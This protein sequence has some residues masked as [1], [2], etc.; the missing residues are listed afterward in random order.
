MNVMSQPV[1][2]HDLVLSLDDRIQYLAYKDL[3]DAVQKNNADSGSVVVVNAKTGEILA[4]ANVPSYNPNHRPGSA[5]SSYRNRA[6]T[7][8]FEPG[9]TMKPFSITNALLSGKYTPTTNVDTNPGYFEFEGHTIHDDQAN[10]GVISV[11]QVLQRSSN[12]WGIEND[13]IITTPKFA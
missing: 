12:I 4:L 2:G 5:D 7:D 10:N 9:S 13:F 11:T 8:V 3:L 1:Q 6:A